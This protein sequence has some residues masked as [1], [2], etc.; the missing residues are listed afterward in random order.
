[1]DSAIT[2][3][4]VANPKRR[5]RARRRINVNRLKEMREQ[6]KHK[7]DGEQVK[8]LK[9]NIAQAVEMQTLLQEERAKRG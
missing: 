9:A 2:E 6:V 5:L 3:H 7:P 8:I 1:M 4:E